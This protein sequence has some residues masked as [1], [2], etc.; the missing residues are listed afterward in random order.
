[1]P[2]ANY[3]PPEG[4]A[5][6][7]NLSSAP[8]CLL[9]I[10]FKA[11]LELLSHLIQLF[12]SVLCASQSNSGWINGGICWMWRN[13]GSAVISALNHSWCLLCYL[14]CD[15]PEFMMMWVVAAW[16][17]EEH[18]TWVIKVLPH[19]DLL[20]YVSTESHWQSTTM[21]NKAGI[22]TILCLWNPIELILTSAVRN[23]LNLELWKGEIQQSG[24]S[25]KG[26]K[27]PSMKR[28]HHRAQG[29][30]MDIPGIVI[31]I[32]HTVP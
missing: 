32:G 12:D 14:L 21:S 3:T 18:T 5:P 7:A 15:I 23:V 16:F 9:Y 20:W 1:M 22:P 29:V 2:V 11:A 19:L 27:S 17:D 26:V 8:A 13:A 6:L 10:V 30:Q 25:H 31:N 24:K 4:W 28:G